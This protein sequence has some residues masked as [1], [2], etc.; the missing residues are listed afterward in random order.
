[1]HRQLYGNVLDYE[2]VTVDRKKF[3][4]SKM[5]SEYCCYL[6]DVFCVDLQCYKFYINFF[7]LQQ[8]YPHVNVFFLLANHVSFNEVFLNLC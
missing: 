6:F 7:F 3:K 2:S 5:K 8:H 1:M 4:L